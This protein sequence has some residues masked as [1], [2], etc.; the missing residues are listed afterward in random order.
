MVGPTVQQDLFS[1]LF[2]FRLQK[3]ALS[4]DIA[5]MYRQIALDPAEKI[6]TDFYGEI[7]TQTLSS[8]FE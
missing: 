3:V 4:G 6:F 8:S 1:I 2:R 5:K 7:Q